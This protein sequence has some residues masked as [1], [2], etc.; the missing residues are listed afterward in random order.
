MRRRAF[1]ATATAVLAAPPAALAVRQPKGEVGIL[2]AALELEQL[3]AYAYDAGVASGLLDARLVAT[4]QALRDHE[5]AHAEAVSALLEALGGARPKP[6]ATPEE[7]DAM[8]ERLE[9]QGRLTA[10]ASRDDLFALL[11]ELEER[12][13]AGYVAAAGNL[14]DVRLIQTS[15]TIAAAQGA[16]LVVIRGVLDRDP[17]PAALESA[18]G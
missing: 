10:V 17:V 7:A 9:L 14:E 13:V 4:V 16:H 6:P 11:H 2:T 18:R 15:A 1:L 3:T 12:Q 5:Q 8:L